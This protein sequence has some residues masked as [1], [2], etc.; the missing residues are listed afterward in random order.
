MVVPSAMCSGGVVCT[1][2]RRFGPTQSNH[3]GLVH[4]FWTYE[5]TVMCVVLGVEV[6]AKVSF[7]TQ[8]E[9]SILRDDK[10]RPLFQEVIVTKLAVTQSTTKY[11][12]KASYLSNNTP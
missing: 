12:M 6:L 3:S 9:M 11:Q 2:P 4:C 10:M 7:I 8:D 1:H 5:K